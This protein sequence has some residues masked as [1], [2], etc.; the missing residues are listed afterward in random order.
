MDLTQVEKLF[1][2]K[3]GLG[4]RADML[5]KVAEAIETLMSRRGVRDRGEY[6]TLIAGDADAFHEIVD[7]LT[8][9]ETYFYREAA[10]LEVFARRLVPRILADRGPEHRLRVLSAGCSTGEEPYS[11]VIALLENHCAIPGR[12]H[13]SV[14]GVD[15]DRTAVLKAREG[16]F[17]GRSFRSLDTRVLDR[18]FTPLEHSRYRI[19]EDIRRMVT[20]D[21]HNL[22]E[23]PYPPALREMDVVFY[24][25][26]SI[27]FES[28]IQKRIFRNLADILN[29]S[30]YLVV[31]STETLSH[32]FRLLRLTEIDGVFLY[33][34]ADAAAGVAAEGADGGALAGRSGPMVNPD[35]LRPCP[36]ILFPLPA[37]GG[38][39]GPRPSARTRGGAP[40][41]IPE[42]PGPNSFSR[43]SMPGQ[44]A[45]SA[46]TRPISAPPGNPKIA[47]LRSDAGGG[48][49]ATGGRP[50]VS[51]GPGAAPAAPMATDE[52]RYAAAREM[53]VN[54]AY[55]R[56]LAL[57]DGIGGG[58]IPAELLRAGILLNLNRTAEARRACEAVLKADPWNIEA[59]MLL[60]IIAKTE[61]DTETALGCFKAVIYGQTANWL[62]H[63]YLAGILQSQGQA[64]RARREYGIVIRLLEK[65]GFADHGLSI[66]PLAFTESQIIHLCRQNMAGLERSY[67]GV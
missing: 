6:L 32:D 3:T 8:I 5:G 19:R 17:G 54:K 11:L 28:E 51:P 34:K 35:L 21:F 13:F 14:T 58:F 65:G 1:R 25:N 2:E 48:R 61:N 38:L 59:S 67:R 29:P 60:G 40:A 12:L 26:V 63:F 42:S 43:R 53:A 62:A 18:Y 50:A 22:L 36:P 45:D 46:S 23:T 41:S 39:D 47:A 66:F 10:Q 56:A 64:E 49:A 37:A 31:S 9:N 24:R 33:A 30:G 20:F 52:G 4:I 16:I 15:I 55:D 7:L 57:L 44:Q 27:Y